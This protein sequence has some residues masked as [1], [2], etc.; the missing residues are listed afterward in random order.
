M[1]TFDLEEREADDRDARRP[2]LEVEGDAAVGADV[3]GAGDEERAVPLAPADE[4]LRHPRVA[5]PLDVHHPLER[6]AVHGAAVR[7][8]ELTSHRLPH[9][10][11]Q[12]QLEP[13]LTRELAREPGEPVPSNRL[14]GDP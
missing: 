1:T 4:R 10:R 12:G 11:R 6:T 14:D 2:A 9:L 5:R 3:A 7:L 13:E 8:V